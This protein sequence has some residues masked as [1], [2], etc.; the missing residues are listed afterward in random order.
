MSLNSKYTL[1]I[2]MQRSEVSTL[3]TSYSFI[4]PKLVGAI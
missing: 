3:P 4:R 1:N 2:T